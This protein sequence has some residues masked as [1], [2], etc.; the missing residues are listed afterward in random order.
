MG[1]LS[2]ANSTKKRKI[3]LV[4]AN[5][6]GTDALE[7]PKEFREIEEALEVADYG[8]L[9]KVKLMGATRIRDLRRQ[10]IKYKPHIVH[11]S[12][13]GIDN[14]I[15]LE[16]SNG[17]AEVMSSQSL[18][19]LFRLSNENIECVILNACDSDDTAE[20]I[21]EHIDYSIGM[22]APIGDKT[23]IDFSLGFYDGLAGRA[24]LD[25]ETA[26][27]FG[28]NA[29][30]QAINKPK[31]RPIRTFVLKP[32]PQLQ[33]LLP[34][35]FK[36]QKTNSLRLEEQS[37]TT[38][39]F[40]HTI[41]H[42]Y[43]RTN[44]LPNNTENL[45][46][47]MFIAKGTDA[48]HSFAVHCC[49]EMLGGRC[50]PNDDIEKKVHSIELQGCEQQS[51][52]NC[53]YKYIQFFQLEHTEQNQ[54]DVIR[55]WFLAQR[56][57]NPVVVLSFR[58]KSSPQHKKINSIIQGAIDLLSALNI[59]GLKILTLFAC[60]EP[61]PK[62]WWVFTSKPPEQCLQMG[63]LRELERKDIYDWLEDLKTKTN[64][65]HQLEKNWADNIKQASLDYQKVL[66]HLKD[67]QQEYVGKPL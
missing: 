41:D 25:Y 45:I 33:S 63:E 13:H 4:A 9:F 2:T 19:D 3:L 34:I 37:N 36:R 8:G 5:P 20:A 31:P 30:G 29:I 35:L 44:G 43:L 66:G 52:E 50:M 17:K 42:D 16:N 46:F 39:W 58:I 61:L 57:K 6:V 59:Q 14:G 23:A 12:G 67:I 18:A 49:I 32:T 64:K 38:P 26:F 51:V 56:D 11:F 28:K 54:K 21:G 10:L 7:L 24:N 60:D 55:Q 47:G 40:H 15:L 53:I 48:P 22:N 27:K 65:P 1:R 62:K